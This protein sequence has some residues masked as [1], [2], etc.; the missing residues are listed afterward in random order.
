MITNNNR[1]SALEQIMEGPYKVAAKIKHGAYSLTDATGD[2]LARN[3]PPSQMR[4]IGAD[5]PWGDSNVVQSITNH[6]DTPSGREYL[7]S[8]KGQPKTA[9]SW[10]KPSAFDDENTIST[11]WKRKGGTPKPNPSPQRTPLP[12]PPPTMPTPTTTSTTAPTTPSPAAVAN[13]KLLLT[14]NEVY[15]TNLP[16]MG[17]GLTR[18]TLL[19]RWNDDTWSR[20]T[21][22]KWHTPPRKTKTGTRY[23][24]EVR[25]PDGKR[26]RMLSL[27]DYTTPRRQAPD[28][29]WCL[30]RAK[31]LR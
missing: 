30:L 4:P 2:L 6:R 8:W 20:A 15:Q 13:P 7:V 31:T 11:Y 3:V 1:K 14:T 21:I 24:C 26:D 22:S 12:E 19:L 27:A 5:I 28:A 10:E 25:L 23:N 18:R 16:T 29:A 9:T 17:S